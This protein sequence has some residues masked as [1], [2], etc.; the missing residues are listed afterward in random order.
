MKKKEWKIT[1]MIKKRMT[2]NE[3][4]KKKEWKITK[5]WKNEWK[6]EKKEKERNN[7]KMKN[8]Q[9]TEKKRNKNINVIIFFDKNKFYFQKIKLPK[10]LIKS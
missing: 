2:N 5:K 9:K 10:N 8:E 1:K 6:N 4:M 7:E 3:K